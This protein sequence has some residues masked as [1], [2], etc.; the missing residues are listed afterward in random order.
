MKRLALTVFVAAA[1]GAAFGRN[2]AAAD[3]STEA[4]AY[5]A[6]PAVTPIYSW[7]GCYIGGQAGGGWSPNDGILNTVGTLGIPVNGPIA[8]NIVSAQPD[9]ND[10]RLATGGALYSVD[11]KTGKAT[12][13]GKIEG[14]AGSLTDIAWLD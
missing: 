4:P 11:L 1:A 8:F 5:K 10:A 7:S 13:A 2:A 6:V 9:K 12:T 14:V 3:L